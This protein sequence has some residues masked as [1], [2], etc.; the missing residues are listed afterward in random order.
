MSKKVV[1]VGNNSTNMY[2]F[3]NYSR[4]YGFPN[5]HD[6]SS[7]SSKRELLFLATALDET[8]AAEGEEEECSLL[9]G[10]FGG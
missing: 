4:N 5:I 10:Q 1:P 6:F 7:A 2:K 3:T 9:F 8:A